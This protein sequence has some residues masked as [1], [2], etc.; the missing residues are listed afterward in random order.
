MDLLIG[1][2][3]FPKRARTS[4]STRGAVQRVGR[5]R[6]PDHPLSA[7][8][9]LGGKGE[10]GAAP[11]PS[12]THVPS[13]AV[14]PLGTPPPRAVSWAPE[15]VSPILPRGGLSLRAP[16]NIRFSKLW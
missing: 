8:E 6:S 16:S 3:S 5:A 1:G 15:V 9:P 11:C 13:P 4:G 12:S 7:P 14:A 10:S 2:F